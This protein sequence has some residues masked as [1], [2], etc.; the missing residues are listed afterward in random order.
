M[1]VAV[2]TELIV[3]TA[4][5][6]IKTDNRSTILIP[7]HGIR[8]KVSNIKKSLM[9]SLHLNKRKRDVNTL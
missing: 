6:K 3:Y 1:D 9:T 7:F 5:I 4:H 2:I 8:Y